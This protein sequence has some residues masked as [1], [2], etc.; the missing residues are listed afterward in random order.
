MRFG[1]RI[2]RCAVFASLCTAM[3][4]AAQA[5]VG[6]LPAVLAVNPR[7]ADAGPML[8]AGVLV[9]LPELPEASRALPAER[10]WEVGAAVDRAA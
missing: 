2:R 1:L 4:A 5:P 6:A 10:L 3:P 7:L 9:L 8:P